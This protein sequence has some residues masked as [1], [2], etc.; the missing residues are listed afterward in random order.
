[1]KEREIALFIL[2]DIFEEGAYNN[3][4]LRKTLNKHED[5]TSVQKA[6][7]TELVNGTLRNLIN[8][9]YVIDKFSK[10]KT[11]KMKPFILNNIRIAVYQILYMDKIPVSAACNEAVILTKKRNFTNLSGFVNGVLRAIARGKDSIEYP[12][13]KYKA[14]A[15]KY[16]YPDW[17]IKYW[18]EDL[19]F[20]EVEKTCIAFSQ[21]P[22]VSI[23]INTVKTNKAQLKKKFSSEGIAV[24]DNSNFDNS[25]YIYRTSNIAESK[26]YKEGLFHIMDES[27]MLA[28]KI[29]APEKESTVV[30]VCSAPG[31]KSFAIAEFMDNKGTVYSRDVY[32]HKLELVES[33]AKRLGLH[34]VKIQL[35]DASKEDKETKADYVLVDAPCSGFG[36][37]RKKPDIKYNKVYEDIE[38]L[39]KIQRKI[40][41]A[42]A[43][44]VKAGGVLVYST[45]TISHKE[46]I[47]NVKWF[48]REY[49]FKLESIE[50]YLPNNIKSETAKNGYIRLLPYEYGTD[51]FFIARMRKNG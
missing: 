4:I 42:S 12:K 2:M 35:K 6:F 36:L 46:N 1:M 51:G 13:D 10:T 20:E 16:S 38:E 47:D 17:L 29:M 31:G 19:S 15:L 3:I 24:D 26:C 45:C 14:L 21:S 34:S 49:G 48:C 30:D 5:L 28:V 27:S 7:V 23:C 11:S 40:L 32:E 50:P 9:D 41:G 25:L 39:A 44:M 18:L 8:I 33:G 22:R 43:V 37:V